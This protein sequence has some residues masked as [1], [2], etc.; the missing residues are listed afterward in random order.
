MMLQWHVRLLCARALRFSIVLANHPSFSSTASIHMWMCLL[1]D[2]VACA[3]VSQSHTA[4]TELDG[5]ETPT[6]A[7]V[8]EGVVFLVQQRRQKRHQ[9]GKTSH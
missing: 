2:G 8:E 1:P 3:S 9:R 4:Q 5:R 6:V 7:T